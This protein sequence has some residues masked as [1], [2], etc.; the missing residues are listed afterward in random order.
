MRALLIETNTFPQL[1]QFFIFPAIDKRSSQNSG[2]AYSHDPNLSSCHNT[3]VF[4]NNMGEKSIL[5]R[6]RA[7]SPPSRVKMRQLLSTTMSVAE[8]WIAAAA[9]GK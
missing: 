2:S 9:S 5:Q 1:E 6:C 8:L 3:I 7:K 4:Y